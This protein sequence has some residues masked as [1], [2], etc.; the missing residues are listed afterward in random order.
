MELAGNFY[1]LSRP[2]RCQP[3]WVNTTEIVCAHA[4][5]R[6]TST[7]QEEVKD[8][9]GG[10]SSLTRI[11]RLCPRRRC[12][13]FHRGFLPQTSHCIKSDQNRSTVSETTAQRVSPGFPTSNIPLHQVSDQNRST[14]S[15]TTA[16][17]VSPGF[18]T[19]NIPLYQIDCVRDDG[20]AC[21]TGVSYL[22]HPTVSS[23]TRIDRLCPRRRCS[24]FHRG[25][26]PQTSHCIKSDQNRSTV[27]ETTA[28]RV[29]PGFPTSNIPLHQV[30]DQ[31]RSTVSETTVQ[32]VSP[33]FPT[34]NIPQHQVS[35]FN[36]G[37]SMT[38]LTLF[39]FFSSISFAVFKTVAELD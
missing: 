26:L 18:P 27:S 33:G 29:S 23:L 20:A 28:Q 31:S 6:V 22:K 9:E 24:V 35:A 38:N 19:S 14:V 25:F 34:S 4:Q 7:I 3:R 21:F 11:D 30:S 32:R 37:S 36:L 1:F 5:C 39:P 17:R 16:Q 2:G 13:V 8:E 12:S 15:E 10:A